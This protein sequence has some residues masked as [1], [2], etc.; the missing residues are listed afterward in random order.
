[1]IVVDAHDDPRFNQNPMVIGDPKIVFYAGYAI[2]NYEGIPFAS[3]CVVDKKSKDLT[4]HQKEALKSLAHQVE[5][6]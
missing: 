2:K 5:Q 1:M 4:P 6:L 3:I